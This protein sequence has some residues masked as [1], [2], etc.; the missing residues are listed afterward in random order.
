MSILL[1]CEQVRRVVKFVLALG[2]TAETAQLIEA[3]EEYVCTL[4]V[5]MDQHKYAARG[6]DYLIT[7]VNI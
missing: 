5:Y 4:L 7:K 6:Y 2:D 3:A 1:L